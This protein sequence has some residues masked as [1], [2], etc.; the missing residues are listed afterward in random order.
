MRCDRVTE[1]QGELRK[2]YRQ[3]VAELLDELLAMGN[4]VL[5][6]LDESTTALIA[7]DS[8]RA[9][10]VKRGYARVQSRHH[11]LQDRILRTIALQA[12]VASDLRMFATFMR[13]N[14]HVERMAG[15]CRNIARAVGEDTVGAEDEQVRAQVAEM[16]QHARRVIE[17][18][19]EAYGRRDVELAR[20]LPDL[21]DPIDILNRAIFRRTID[22]ADDDRRLD[23]A[24]HMVLV[25]RYIERMSDHA[26]GIGEQAIFAVT[27]EIGALS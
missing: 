16:A 9:A 24:L 25:A 3:Q 26:V 10:G 7:R 2:A 23:W 19:L 15:L 21:D 11:D 6:L 1:Q 5:E 14:I 22:L 17:R 4:Q 13:V 18:A 20:T 27:G 8:D 12:P